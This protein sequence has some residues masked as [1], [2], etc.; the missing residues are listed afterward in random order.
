MQRVGADLKQKFLDS[1]KTT[2]NTV[3][4]YA[5]FSKG[6]NF[7]QEIDR[8]IE[9]EFGQQS[10]ETNSNGSA[11]DADQDVGL[12]KLNGGR[13]IDYVLQEAPLESFNEYLFALSS[14]V[15]YW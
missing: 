4:Q 2:W 12:G 14:H 6:E 1:I 15:T 3:Y 5:T 13:R 7:E 11:D 8:V 9:G 10:V